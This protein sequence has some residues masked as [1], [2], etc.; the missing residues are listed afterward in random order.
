M[1]PADRKRVAR[2]R[3]IFL[4]GTVALRSWSE[5]CASVP[6]VFATGR[7]FFR[8]GVVRSR[9]MCHHFPVGST[10]LCDPGPLRANPGPDRDRDGQ[11]W[12]GVTSGPASLASTYMSKR[13]HQMKRIEPSRGRGERAKAGSLSLGV[14]GFESGAPARKRSSIRFIRCIPLIMYVDAS[15]PRPS[16]KSSTQPRRSSA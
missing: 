9:R 13:I 11:S 1:F 14:P 8:R 7:V 16:T 12:R 4:D 2:R 10:R 15:G 5:R 6:Q 3:S